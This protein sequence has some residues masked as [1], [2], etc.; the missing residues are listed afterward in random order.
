MPRSR[1]FVVMSIPGQTFT[2]A[3]NVSPS[4]TRTTC[5]GWLARTI[6]TC[7]T[8][9]AESRVTG[10]EA[11]GGVSAAALRLDSVGPK[12]APVGQAEQEHHHDG[13]R[14]PTARRMCECAEHNHNAR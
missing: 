3:S 7:C 12:V 10:P 2:R 14:R 9:S 11:L 13:Y 5:T 6:G 8:C 1:T 4:S